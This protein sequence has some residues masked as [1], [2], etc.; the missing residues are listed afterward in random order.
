M[1]KEL[2]HKYFSGETTPVEEK[3][4]IDWAESS[5]EN[6]QMYLKERKFW[7]AVTVNNIEMPADAAKNRKKIN[8]WKYAAVAASIALLFS[9]FHSLNDSGKPE[10]KWQSVWA[11]PGQR[12]RIVLDD[13]TVVWLNS[14]STLA[15]PSSFGSGVRTVKLNGEGYFEVKKDEKKAFIVQT[16]QY[17]ISVLGTSFNVFS[18][19]NKAA[20]EI[21]LL[22]GSVR[23]SHKG[24]EL[25]DVT[26]FPNEKAIE[27]DGRLVKGVIDNFNHFRW[28]E[29]LI[30]FDEEPFGDMMEKFSLYFDIHIKIEN[31]TLMEYRPTGK[32]RHSDGI[33]HALKVLQRDLR[34]TYNRDHERNEIVIK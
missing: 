32:F 24:R 20:F 10:E 7:D 13:S 27:E 8:I 19:E 3:E 29:G 11:P 22:K 16:S 33:D 1:E 25:S 4:I 17:D 18:Y 6:Y 12:A 34:F 2:L 9:L 31:P 14:Q 26:L 30:C 23:V 15:Y 28:R 5:P 21:S